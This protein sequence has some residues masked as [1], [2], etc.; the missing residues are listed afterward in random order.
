MAA[1]AVVKA[2]S[3]LKRIIEY[4]KSEKRFDGYYQKTSGRCVNYDLFGDRMVD[5]Y[6]SGS[7]GDEKPILISCIEN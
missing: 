3:D 1:K 4:F 7:F 6:L 5:A 2:N